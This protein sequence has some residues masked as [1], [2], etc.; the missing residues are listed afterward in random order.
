MAINYNSIVK[1]FLISAVIGVGIS[2]SKVYFFHIMLIILLLS[3]LYLFAF[4]KIKLKKNTYTKFHYFLYVFFLWYLLS[5]LW[6]IEPFYTLQYL[7]YIFCGSVISLTIIYYINNIHDLNKV[8]TWLA[9]I[10]IIEIIF[11]LL[12]VFTN[13]RLPISPFSSYLHLFSRDGTNFSAFNETTTSYLRSMPTGFSWNPNTLATTMNIILPFFMFHTNK[14]IKILGILSILILI[15]AAGSRGNFL[16]FIFMCILFL[17]FYNKKRFILTMLLIPLILTFFYSSNEYL[18]TI[19]NIKIQEALSSFHQLEKYVSSNEVKSGSIGA[20]KQLIRN[21]I[22]ELKETNGLGVGGGA[23]NAAQEKYGSKFTSMHNFWI[24][25]LVEGGICFF[26]I[27]V[28]W[29]LTL[30]IYLY[31]ISLISKEKNIKYYSSSATLALLGFVIGAISPST[32]IYILPMWIMYG[33]A[34]SIINVYKRRKMKGV[35]LK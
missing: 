10:F 35:L 8:F 30:I 2:Y 11:C 29:Y 12:E 22:N 31:K 9:I 33:F 19:D 32:T 7:V 14:K 34:I 21:G 13:F 24:E 3:T 17:L 16:A 25:L 1:W 4:N 20:R 27:F 6:S 28:V 5:L 23:S 15:I 26:I 18:Y